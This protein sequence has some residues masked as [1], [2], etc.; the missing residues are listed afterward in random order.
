M[1]RDPRDLGDVFERIDPDE[2]RADSPSLARP[3][4]VTSS[5]ILKGSTIE[6]TVHLDLDWRF[7]LGL[8]VMK[9]G[10]RI[11]GSKLKTKVES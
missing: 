1:S 2:L 5:E 7:R 4:R 11:M 3:I 10:A 6:M 9:L 8:S